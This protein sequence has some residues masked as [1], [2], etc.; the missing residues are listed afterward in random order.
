MAMSFPVGWD[1]L[2]DQL[3]AWK[4]SASGPRVV[5]CM[6]RPDLEFKVKGP[7]KRTEGRGD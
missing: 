5:S 2:W 1:A 3:K 7:G 6:L 4:Y